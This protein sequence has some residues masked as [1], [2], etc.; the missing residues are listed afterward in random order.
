MSD[1]TRDVVVI[2]AGHNGLVAAAYLAR[3]GHDVLVLERSSHVGGA[4]TT[5]VLFGGYRTSPCAYWLHVLQHRVVTDLDLRAHGWSTIGI[6]PTY[7]SPY[8]DGRVLVQWRDWRR[9]QESIGTFSRRDAER[10]ADYVAFWRSAGALVG[11]YALDPA[12]PTVEQLR[13]VV[14]GTADAEILARLENQTVR[15]LMDEFFGNDQVQA[16]LLPNSDIVSLDQPGEL[17][18]WAMTVAGPGVAPEDQGIPVGGMGTLT[19]ALAA[20]AEKNGVEIRLNQNVDEVL[21]ED[22][23]AVGVR[24]ENGSVVRSRVVVSN[25]DPKRTFASLLPGH[26]APGHARDAVAALETESGSL[27]FH[28]ALSELP[29]FSRHLGPDFEPTLLGML[30]IAPSLAYVESSL[31]DAAA[32]VPTAHPILIGQIPSVYDATTAPSGKHLMSIRVKFQPSRL[33]E[34]D[35]ASLKPQLGRQLID[36]MTEYAPNFADSVEDWVVYTPDDMEARAG[37][38]DGNIHHINHAAGQ[39]LGDRL[40]T[41]GGYVTPVGNLFM[42]GAGAH[43]GGEVTGA[44]GHNAAAVVHRALTKAPVSGTFLKEAP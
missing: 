33:K 42:C 10:F 25:A 44:P 35:W 14:A 26:S 32:G 13:T 36:M 40:F 38:T 15:E 3:A 19:S 28:A 18:G 22:G 4:A 29:D 20:A 27:K 43:P 11:R 30:R 1:E 6:D 9:T 39:V 2:G 24:L 41:G 7:V 5:E 23:C 8:P 31:A 17:L 37:L 34:G 21:V 12:P 16:A